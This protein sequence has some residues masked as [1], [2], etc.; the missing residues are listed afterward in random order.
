MLARA[1]AVGVRTPYQSHADSRK[2]VNSQK[3][4]YFDAHL[5]H[6]SQDLRYGFYGDIDVAVIEATEMSPNGDIILGAGMGMVFAVVI[7]YLAFILA[8]GV[9]VEF[10]Y[11]LTNNELD[12]DKILGRSRRKRVITVDFK[13][14]EICANINDEKYSHE[15]KNTVSVTKTIDVTGICDYD[16]YFV[17]FAGENGKTRVLFQPTDK[18][19]DAMKLINPRAIH[20]L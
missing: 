17:D 20:I 7:C 1:E 14:I 6:V 15:F 4:S 3:M 16:V 11:A 5:S 8:K 9:F 2:L 13:N 19:K 12:I 10:E 18:M